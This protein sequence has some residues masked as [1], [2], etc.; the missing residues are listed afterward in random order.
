[1][2]TCSVREEK[3][4]FGK[5]SGFFC[6]V[7]RAIAAERL[8]LGKRPSGKKGRFKHGDDRREGF[9][10][11][12]GG[13]KG[14]RRTRIVEPIAVQRYTRFSVSKPR[15]R[16]GVCVCVC[17]YHVDRCR[18][19]APFPIVVFNGDSPV[20]FWI[21]SEASNAFISISSSFPRRKRYFLAVNRVSG[22]TIERVFPFEPAG[23]SSVRE[24][25]GIPVRF[26]RGRIFVF[27]KA[28]K[29]LKYFDGPNHIYS[30]N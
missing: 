17:V 14:R 7:L 16:N 20:V 23:S 29:H 27:F 3:C 4:N 10:T 25:T 13:L 18:L 11:F 15:N 5:M 8:V 1:V 19:S 2:D 21:P 24:K 22:F 12:L 30:S 6:F 28:R 26:G 9:Y